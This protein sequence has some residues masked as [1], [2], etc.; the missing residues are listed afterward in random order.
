MEAYGHVFREGRKLHLPVSFVFSSRLLLVNTGL[1]VENNTAYAR[2][3]AC[4]VENRERTLI[5]KIV[6]SYK[7]NDSRTL[8]EDTHSHSKYQLNLLLQRHN[9][10]IAQEG[11]TTPL[12]AVAM[13]AAV[14][15][16]KTMA[17]ER[18]SPARG[19]CRSITCSLH[20]NINHSKEEG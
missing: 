11:L 13:V 19:R 20:Q 18:K 6:K 14:A 16:T 4:Q 9:S 15:I 10:Q 8:C 12:A 2:H 17:A 7:W 1:P 5:D 3:T